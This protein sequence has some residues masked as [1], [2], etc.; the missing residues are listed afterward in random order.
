VGKFNRASSDRQAVL[1]LTWLE[2]RTT[3][4]DLA[5]DGRELIY[6]VGVGLG[7][8]ATTRIDGGPRVH[9]VCPL[10]T[11]DGIYAFIVPSPK[12]RDLHRD[13]RYALHTIPLERNEDAF[14]L[15]GAATH[16]SDEATRA[17]LSQQFVDERA[18]LKMPPPGPEQHLFE[19]RI[20]TAVLTR[21]T[22]HGDPAPAHTVWRAG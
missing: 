9:P 11:D 10:I 6:D 1:V 22:G 4:P 3:Q 18:A 21:T 5:R 12:Q 8:L 17:Y 15:A 14:Y 20:D 19:L 13:G 2:F 16:A 7:L